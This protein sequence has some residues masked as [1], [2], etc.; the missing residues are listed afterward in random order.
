MS[1]KK[2]LVA[3][4]KSEGGTIGSFVRLPI[5]LKE[6]AQ[7]HCIKNKITLT[8]LIIAGISAEVNSEV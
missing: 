8:D 2:N 5:S 6:R 3:P 7:I 4:S 1:P